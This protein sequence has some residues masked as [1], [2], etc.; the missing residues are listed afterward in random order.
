MELTLTDLRDALVT[1]TD[2]VYHYTAPSQMTVP[3]IVWAEDSRRDLVADNKHIEAGTEGTIDLF[4]PNEDD[5]LMTAI[6]GVLNDLQIP[7][8]QNSVQ[9]EKDTGLIHY[10]W[11]WGIYGE[12]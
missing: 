11:V 9:Y 1:L 4:T 8:Y 5:P 3:Y 10:E 12:V 6:P 7:W 2:K